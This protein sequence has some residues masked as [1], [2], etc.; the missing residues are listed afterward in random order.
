MF[1]FIRHL[2]RKFPEQ[3]IFSFGQKNIVFGIPN[4]K[5]I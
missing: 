3:S 1:E 5:L 2:K 4:P